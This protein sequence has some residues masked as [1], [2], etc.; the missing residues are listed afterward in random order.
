MKKSIFFILL[1]SFALTSFSQVE[2]INEKTYILPDAISSQ[3]C[4]P[5]EGNDSIEI[6]IGNYIW[7]PFWVDNFETF[8]SNDLAQLFH[9]DDSL[10][11]IGVAG[12]MAV[13]FKAL[14]MNNYLGIA[15]SSFNILEEK[16]LSDILQ[17][18]GNMMPY[19]ELIFD[20]PVTVIGDFYVRTDFAR[21]PYYM[22]N[23]EVHKDTAYETKYNWNESYSNLFEFHG[24][25]ICL[26]LIRTDERCDRQTV[27]T[28]N[29]SLLA[30][31]HY[32]DDFVETYEN[33][34]TN[35]YDSLPESMKSEVHGLY[36]FPLIGEDEED[37]VS[38][39]A[40]V[41]VENYTYVFPNPASEN[42]TVQSSFKIHG[43]EI[44]NEQGQK[45]LTTNSNGYNTSIDVS[46][47]PK[48]TY[49]VKIMTKSGTTNKKII[50]Q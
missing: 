30:D 27:M 5:F 22:K 34:W 23:G 38:S 44:F 28:A 9:T 16:V 46:S 45:I 8:E 12:Y 31:V 13:S 7:W 6:E 17:K 37:T 32:I 4:I 41:E 40:S 18:N 24:Q 20:N 14:T 21:P 15:D 25:E 39:V 43:I 47:Y 48:G 33:N 1:S 11:I 49:I 26:R 50:V 3:G 2:K 19:Y 36:L 35:Y 29:M 10:E 42:I